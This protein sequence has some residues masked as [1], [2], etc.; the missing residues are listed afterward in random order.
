MNQFIAQINI[1]DYERFRAACLEAC[2][3][4]RATWSNWRNGGPVEKKY[5]PI[6]DRIATEMFGRAVFKSPALAGTPLK[7][8]E[9][10]G[11]A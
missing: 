7:G 9:E 3:V 1:Y 2:N 4:S 5:Q 10:G 11:A 8:G 6:I